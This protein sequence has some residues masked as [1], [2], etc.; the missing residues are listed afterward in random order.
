MRKGGDVEEKIEIERRK[1]WGIFYVYII[2]ISL[3]L[4]FLT[5]VASAA[6]GEV[7][8][9]STY[10]STEYDSAA[11]VFADGEN[12]YVMVRDWA[13][14]KGGT[15]TATITN[16][17]ETITIPLYDNGTSPDTKPNDGEYWGVFTIGT[18]TTDD[19]SDYLH[20]DDGKEATITADVGGDGNS[21]TAKIL[22]YYNT[23]PTKITVQPGESIQEAINNLPAEGGVVEL[24]PG[25]HDVYDTIVINKSNVTIMG[26]HNSE[27]RTHDSS[28]DIFALHHKNPSPD[29][30]WSVQPI[31][32]NIVL[33][34]F[35]VSSTYTTYTGQRNA[36]IRAY[37]VEHLTVKDIYDVSHIWYFVAV[38]ITGGITN[39]QQE[40][41]YIK[42]NTIYH[43]SPVFAWSK[44]VYVIN[45]T[46]ID[47]YQSYGIDANRNNLY[48]Y[49]IRNNVVGGNHANLHMYSSQ[50]WIVEDNI[51]DGNTRYCLDLG[52][53]PQ[54]AIIKNNT[55]RNGLWGGIE[56]WPVEIKNIMFVNN[57][58]YDNNGPGILV[59]PYRGPVE[60]N[61]RNNVIYNNLRDGIKM[62]NENGALI[63]ANNII[64]N[65][66]GYGINLISGNLTIS[67]ND[68]WNNT[69]GNYNGVS[70][71]E[72]DI[73]VD[74]LF[75]DPDNGDFHLKSQAGR[76]NGSAWV[77]DTETSPCIDAGDPVDDYSNEPE[78]NGGRINLGAY[79]NTPEASKSSG[80][81]TTPPTITASSPT[82]E[83]VSIDTTISVTFSEAMNKTSA[84]GA[85]SISPS[86]SGSFSWDGNK[87]IFT[88]DSNLA[89][90]TT[91]TV[92]ISTSAEDLAGNNLESPYSWQFTT[93]E[94]DT[95]PPVISNIQTSYITSNSATITWTTDE[96][97]TSLVKYGTTSGSYP[98]SQ[99]DTSY[100][101]S[102]SITLTNLQPNTTYYFVVNS[103]DKAGNSAQSSEYKFTTNAWEY[104]W[105]EAEDAD[106]ITPD[107]KIVN[108]TSAS[109]SK[110]IWVPEGAGWHP[111]RGEAIYT[112]H[113]HSP[114]NYV[115]WGRIFAN[116]ISNNSFFVQMD[117]SP[118]YLWTI[119]PSNSWQWDEV[120]HWGNGTE[121]DPEI[122]P[123][124]FTLS[125][126]EHTLRIKQ[127][128][129]GTKL[130]KLLVTNDIKYTPF[131]PPSIV[132]FS[133]ENTTLT[134]YVNRTYT[135]SVTVSQPVSNAWF[136]DGEDLHNNAQSWTHTWEHTGVHNVTYIGT[137]E[138]GTV[139][140]TW[141]VNVTLNV[142]PPPSFPSPNETLV[143][144]SP[145]SKVVKRGES[146]NI[147]I[148]VE[149][150][151]EIA[152]MQANLIFDP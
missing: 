60:A 22:A 146:F 111:K 83:N 64:A 102:H 44:N 37:N 132:S 144:I 6:G 133:P 40:N 10:K 49:I 95:T 85:F 53:V 28:K 43:S 57:R 81:D 91:Y 131:N 9:I 52:V 45:N 122:D 119:T 152:G 126:G 65:N 42:N 61:I 118:D 70:A 4:S 7:D 128:E 79:G 56:I 124:I 38:G 55:M 72:G 1:K 103:T 129:D 32:R 87:M 121:T 130:D 92:N 106:T 41:I 66:G 39:G 94:E 69:L 88:P 120:N 137:N 138:N 14:T 31:L 51:L 47:S 25:V 89:Y 99:E 13:G 23:N 145:S 108:D 18:G 147:S 112:I 24:A 16:G 74:P 30:D 48:V 116:T 101:T 141:T 46:I 34:G 151:E 63:V 90:N 5:G 68:I 136:L 71:G 29:E 125:E 107:F 8:G 15:S 33:K 86:V 113:I 59:T 139:S 77:N 75:A 36:L 98:Y 140:L 26:T 105:I 76:W 3:C 78:P 115:I 62:E 96:P 100:T 80:V 134:Q 143:Y 142:T 21:G 35:K 150:G 123:V 114:G 17:A 50:Y 97:S 67:Y 20:I 110:Y 54:H 19:S 73:S 109:N 84:E 12:V 27:I 148:Y 93:I 82:G 135:F 104:I 117:D 58:I 11:S 2:C 127:R 149:P